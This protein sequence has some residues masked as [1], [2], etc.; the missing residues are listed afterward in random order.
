MCSIPF[1]QDE[2]T[3]LAN[4]PM[5]SYGWALG[6]QAPEEWRY[7]PGMNDEYEMSDLGRIR[8]ADTKA[9]VHILRRDWYT[10]N[11]MYCKTFPELAKTTR[12]NY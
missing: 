3:K 8:R 12:I 2:Q 11:R 4:A 6:E 7:I 1:F 9:L 10:S 5:G